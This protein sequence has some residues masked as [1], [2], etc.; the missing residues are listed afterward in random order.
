MSAT[1]RTGPTAAT[2]EE[3]AFPRG[4]VWGSATAAY[5]IEG[6]VT[7]D[8][9]V[10][11]IWDTFC[12]VPGA[13]VG[14]E[15]GDVAC[16]HYRRYRED[17]DLMAALGLRAYRFS[18][19]WP[20][21]SPEPGRVNQAGL[22]HYSRL[23][24]ALLERDVT[25]WLTLYHWDLPQVLEDRGGWASRDVVGHFTEYALRVHGALGDRVRH[26]IT[27]NEPWCSAILGYVGG[28][29]APGRQDAQAGA[30]AVHHLLLA[31]GTAVRALRAE[32][33]TASLGV[34]LNPTVIDPVDP[35]DRRCRDAARRADAL[36]NTVFLDPLFR[37][38][39]PG[40]AVDLFARRGAVLPV[41]PGDLD[42]IAAP[43]DF[44]GVNYYQ[45]HE[46][47]ARHPARAAAMAAGAGVPRATID[48][49][50]HL[51]RAYVVSRGL[52]VTAMGWEVQP[53]GLTRLLTRLHADYTGPAGI[54]LYIT[55]NG[56]AYDDEPSDDGSVADLDRTRYITEHL[57]ATHAAIR[58]GAD[59]RG[60]FVWSLL[61]NFEWA[62][63]YAKR[64]GVVRVDFET[65]ERTPK[66]SALTFADIART[67]R[68]P[69][70]DTVRP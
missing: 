62:Y 57:R 20:R 9:R 14:E 25:P 46:V 30:A 56:A 36:V 11:S 22:D 67:G 26:W 33:P 45:G 52:P 51:A 7:E 49:M 64:F 68:V 4:F 24:D 5:Q 70:S 31:H 13:V 66:Q 61:D 27:L 47:A 37:A 53:D 60:Y 10:P 59:V 39:Y 35:A 50:A 23:V 17:V 1:P 40:D 63:G 69:A 2:G 18:T 34:T 65:L 32:D 12:R 28:Q 3:C 29:H 41:E 15:N 48:P 58:A 19:A 8:G 43:L 44:L 54:P 6:A 16:Q 38:A 55:E 21:I 42:T